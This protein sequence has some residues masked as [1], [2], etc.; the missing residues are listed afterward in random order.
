MGRFLTTSAAWHPPRGSAK[1]CSEALVLPAAAIVLLCFE[2]C[3]GVAW[4][5]PLR[6]CW[7][8]PRCGQAGRCR[9]SGGDGLRCRA[10]GNEACTG[11]KDRTETPRPTETPR[12]LVQRPS[13]EHSEAGE[14]RF[15][16]IV[17]THMTGNH[18]KSGRALLS[19]SGCPHF[20]VFR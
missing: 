5:D 7:Q 2:S 13:S 17:A 20:Q 15:P 10:P 4:K 9:L 3:T 11:S 6:R 16:C 18:I 12:V 8:L 14:R 1:R 19:S